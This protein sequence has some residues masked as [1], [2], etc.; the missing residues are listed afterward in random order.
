[1]PK[2]INNPEDRKISIPASLRNTHIKIVENVNPECSFSA[3]L[4]TIIEA[5]EQSIVPLAKYDTLSIAAGET[6][7][8]SVK[9]GAVLIY[10]RSIDSHILDMDAIGI[11]FTDTIY[12]AASVMALAEEKG[13]EVQLVKF[14]EYRFEAVWARRKT[15]AQ[16]MI[17]KAQILKKVKDAL[18]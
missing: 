15:E 14:P 3:N 4:R 1:M 17:C 6:E 13:Y 7:P 16:C 5:Y 10:M 2:R 9:E 12:T 8:V 18:L 11:Q